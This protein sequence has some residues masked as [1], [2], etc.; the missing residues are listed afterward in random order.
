[1]MLDG[2]YPNSAGAAVVSAYSACLAIGRIIGGLFADRVGEVN[3]FVL[4][5]LIPLL[6]VLCIWMP[7]PTNIIT[8]SIAAVIWALFCGTPLVGELET[9]ETSDVASGVDFFFSRSNADPRG[10]GV[11]GPPAWGGT[12]RSFYLVRTW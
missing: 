5:C 1:M 7:A 10:Q 8:T 4:A 9:V 2:G 12:R 11:R 6:C 3:M